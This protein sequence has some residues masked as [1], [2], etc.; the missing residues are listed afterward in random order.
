MKMLKV[1]TLNS[2]KINRC[3]VIKLFSDCKEELDGLRQ[4]WLTLTEY[5][6]ELKTRKRDLQIL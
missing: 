4:D 6:K 1:S 2:D 5:R 3:H